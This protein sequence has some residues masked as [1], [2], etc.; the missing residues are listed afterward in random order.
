MEGVRRRSVVVWK[1]RKKQEIRHDFR[2]VSSRDAPP[3]L[4]GPLAVSHPRSLRPAE[5]KGPTSLWRREG[6]VLVDGRGWG[7]LGRWVVKMVVH[8]RGE[9]NLPSTV[10]AVDDGFKLRSHAQSPSSILTRVSPIR[11]IKS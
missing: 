9:I 11:K 10:D 2:R 6:H 5:S 1:I 4:L 8:G 3:G 7:E